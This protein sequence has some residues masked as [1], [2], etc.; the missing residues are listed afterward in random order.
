MKKSVLFCALAMFGATALAGEYMPRQQAYSPST[1]Y[2]TP[3]SGS[4]YEFRV[5]TGFD[6][7][8]TG[9]FHG[10]FSAGPIQIGARDYSDIYD[11]IWSTDLELLVP[12]NDRLDFVLGYGFSEGEADLVQVGTVATGPLL[13]QFD[14][15]SA[16]SLTAGFNYSLR[17]KNSRFTPY[18]GVRA[19]VRFVDDMQAD[20]T[21]PGGVLPDLPD[22]P[23]YR[24]SAVFTISAVLG[25]RYEVSS[26]FAVGIEAGYRYVGGLDAND[27][28]LA[29]LGV[30]GLEDINNTDGLSTIPVQVYG[31]FLF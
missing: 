13:A 25:A 21:N 12:L 26:N 24:S 6:F 8:V 30:P 17:P 11:Q 3:S 19:G 18:V 1:G 10:G 9:N 5:K 29:S 14:D 22:T 15:Y 27:A 7:P 23:F 2:N 4:A 28:G 20:F 16:H 31:S